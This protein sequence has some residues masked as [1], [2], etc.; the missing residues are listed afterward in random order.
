[1]HRQVIDTKI[2]NFS[3]RGA[4]LP[5]VTLL[6][7]R[8][9]QTWVLLVITVEQNI[10]QP[11]NVYKLGSVAPINTILSLSLAPPSFHGENIMDLCTR[12]PSHMVIWKCLLEERTCAVVSKIYN[13]NEHNIYCIY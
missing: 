8:Y 9:I 10:P 6:I 13:R 3:L 1:M 12:C 4:T 7:S 5:H 11:C 2:H